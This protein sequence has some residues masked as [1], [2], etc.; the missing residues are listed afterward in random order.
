M[1]HA[2][3]NIP[4]GHTGPLN[5]QL[6]PPP[7]GSWDQLERPPAFPLPQTSRCMFL[8][9]P[10]EL[11]DQIYG[12]L[13]LVPQNPARKCRS[14]FNFSNP[15]NFALGTSLLRT[16]SRI[17]TEASSVLYGSNHFLF[18][19]QRRETGSYWSAKWREVGFNAVRRFLVAIGP[20]NIRRIK[21]ATLLLED[22]TP[23]LNPRLKTPKARRFVH[24]QCLMKVLRLL[25]AKG[26]LKKLGLLF[27]GRRRV[28]KNDTKFLEALCT[29]QADDVEFVRD[30]T[31]SWLGY[32]PPSKQ[33]AAVDKMCLQSMKRKEALP[34]AVEDDDDNDDDDMSRTIQACR[35]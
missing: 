18:A 33:H 12:H 2:S 29:V 14:Y 24:D 32:L 22:A 11:R 17:H 34:D 16:C 7:S 35:V 1:L 25:A 9:L 4:P 26:R 8:E 27:R 19:R 23:Y 30:L 20:K 21:H 15:H 31:Q 10:R 28:D 3:I 6:Q 5:I 13:Y